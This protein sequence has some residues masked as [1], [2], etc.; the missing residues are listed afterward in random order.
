MKKILLVITTMLLFCMTLNAE[1]YRKHRINPHPITATKF[2]LTD[3]NGNY[4]KT[5]DLTGKDF[6]VVS[7]RE[8]GSD[9]QMYAVDRD[10][11]IWWHGLISSGAGGGK[12]KDEHGKLVP[13]GGHET[14][15]GVF[16]ILV[17]RRFH[18]SKTHPDP[19]GIDNMDFELQFTQDGQALHL[20]NTAAMSHGCIH[21]GRQDIAALFKWAHV[22]M[23]VVVMRG[24]Y[25]QFLNE[26]VN[27][28][29]EDIKEYDVER[30]ER[31]DIK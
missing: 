28:F 31:S 16:H 22:G 25:K 24:H 3:V 2:K 30:G 5:V 26:E 29:K 20:G 15:S 18:M 4:I 21:V 13:E 14:S 17:K 23:P 8:P 10:G 11:T 12:L 27:Q 6:I 1:T 7:V 19:S 9:G